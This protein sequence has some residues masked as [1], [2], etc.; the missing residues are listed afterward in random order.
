MTKHTLLIRA[1]A[2]THVGTGHVM[3]CLALAQAWQETGGSV[4]FL[5]SPSSPS[6]EQRIRKEGMNVLSITEQPGSNDDAKVTAQIANKNKIPWIVVDGYHF[7]A[8]YQ[9]ILK[10]YNCKI[11]FLDDFGHTDYYY[12][13]IVLNQNVSA[14]IS[15]YQNYE[16]YTRFL[17]GTNYVLLRREFLKWSDW[18]RDIPDVARKILITFGGSDPDNI[19]LKVIE[20]IKTIDLG[21][22]EIIAVIGGTNPHFDLIHKLVKDHTDIKLIRNTENMP[23]L[24]AW[25]DIAISAGGSTYWELAFMGLPSIIVPIAGNQ[26][27]NAALLKEKDLVKCI[28]ID[29]I[30]DSDATAKKIMDLLMS[31]DER[32]SLSHKM[33]ALI[34][35][36]GSFRVVL[37]IHSHIIRM[38]PVEYSDCDLI[39]SWINEETVR[40]N[41]FHPAKISID[42]HKKW[43]SSVITEKKLLYYIA[44]DLCD[45]PIGQARFKI[46]GDDAVISILLDNDHRGMNLGSKLIQ[47]ATKKF[48]DDTRI[49]KV[50]AYVKTINKPS[51]KAF[52]KAGYISAGLLKINND[53]AY[54]VIISRFGK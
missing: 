11:L 13:D 2:N 54:D 24:M 30:F 36:R 32:F 21:G 6:L 41:S 15:C 45:R 46:E 44:L 38:R 23:E 42:E 8:D 16:Q 12:A 47:S 20:V 34:D 7:G 4:T 33:R 29:E 9:K 53:M 25:A 37:Q 40:A 28:E 19:T 31:R 14:D 5:I 51:L 22:L 26:K 27:P 50:H 49:D 39:F 52:I 48:F 17:L 1:D 10:N 35:G 43:F 3:R 18:Y